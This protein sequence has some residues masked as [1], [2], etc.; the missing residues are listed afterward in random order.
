M[1]LRIF[2]SEAR[3]ENRRKPVLR[4]S[5]TRTDWEGNRTQRAC[6]PSLQGRRDLRGAGALGAA[7]PPVPV[8]EQLKYSVMIG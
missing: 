1:L 6:P 7:D 3:K 8:A 5:F 4:E 2:I